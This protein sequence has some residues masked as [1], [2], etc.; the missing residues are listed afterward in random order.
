MKNNRLHLIKLKEITLFILLFATI[1]VTKLFSQSVF[2]DGK[3]KYVV[4]ENIMNNDSALVFVTGLTD[5]GRTIKD[6][7][8]PDSI[9]TNGKTY[10]IKWIMPYAFSRCTNLESITIP[11]TITSI[12]EGTFFNCTGLLSVTIPN[13]ITSIGNFAFYGCKSLAAIN[14]SDSVLNIES[15]TI[16]SVMKIDNAAIKYITGLTSLIIPKPINIHENAF[17]GC[18]SLIIKKEL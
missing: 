15:G 10:A 14:I 6:V 8:V 13:T 2:D 16:V 11:N 12:G 18:D 17:V 1:G 4:F 9:N 7:V 3:L 5:N